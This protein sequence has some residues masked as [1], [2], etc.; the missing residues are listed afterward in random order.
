MPS[1][2]AA[3]APDQPSSPGSAATAAPTS[4]LATASPL[5]TRR[6]RILGVKVRV[7]DEEAPSSRTWREF[8][9][10]ERETL[11][12]WMTSF[13][14]HF[15]LV[16]IL[17]CVGILT[18]RPREPLFLLAGAPGDSVEVAGP[19]DAEASFDLAPQAEANEEGTAIVLTPQISP[20]PALPTADAAPFYASGSGLKQATDLLGTPHGRVSNGGMEARNPVSRRQRVLEE[21]G[22]DETEHAVTRGLRWMQAHQRPDGGWRFNFHNGTLCDG[23]CR[24]TGTASSTTAATS[25]AL[26]SFFGAGMTHREGEFKEPVRRGIYYLMSRT[27]LSPTG[28][29]FQEGTMYAQGLAGMALGEGY[30]LSRDAE[31][32]VLAQGCVNYIAAAQDPSGGGWRYNPGQ[33]GDTSMLGW[34][35]MALKSA[36]M[37]YLRIPAGTYPKAARFLDSVEGES[38]ASYGYLSSSDATDSTRAIGLLCR[39]Y[40]GWGR[41][42]PGLAAG[43]KYLAQKGPS[44]DDMYFNYYATLVMHHWGGEPWRTWNRKM[45]QHLLYTQSRDGHQ[46]GSWHFSGNNGD[47]GG[48]LYNTAL[49]IMTLEVYYRFL[50]IYRETSV[51]PHME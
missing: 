44:K 20:D 49:A 8:F 48:R 2:P 25:F 16:V 9:Q 6:G 26:L 51:T 22:N 3:P 4:P 45:V 30:A 36:E 10:E 40:Q 1:E 24:D 5:R 28:A 38:G 29:D 39:M 19:L 12:A 41:N 15:L 37:G 14:V 47:V 27:Q 50:P 32:G 43:V 17:A 13:W 18:E 21:N 23:R 35:L 33:P 7:E 42:R 11:P 31:L 46:A 34:Q